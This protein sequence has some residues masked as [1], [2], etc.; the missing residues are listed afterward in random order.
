MKPTNFNFFSYLKM[1]KLTRFYAKISHISLF[2]SSICQKIWPF[3]LLCCGY[4]AKEYKL[5]RD[6]FYN[7]KEFQT[8]LCNCLVLYFCDQE[9]PVWYHWYWF[10]LWIIFWSFVIKVTSSFTNASLLLKSQF[11]N[12]LFSRLKWSDLKML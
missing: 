8:D 4:Y 1:S 7:T 10:R 12:P 9:Y 3:W 2:S 6:L 11:L 5:E